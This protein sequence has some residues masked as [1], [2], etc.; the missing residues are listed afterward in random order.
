M[1]R[2]VKNPE[3]ALVCVLF[4]I[5]GTLLS[6]N[7]AGRRAFSKALSTTFGW[8]DPMRHVNF[9]GAT[10]LMVFDQIMAEK[11]YSPSRMER[12]SF[13]RNMGDELEATLGG[14]DPFL[15]DGVSEVIAKLSQD[16]RYLLG[17]VTG[18]VERCARIKLR[19]FDLD[20]AFSFGGFG[21]DHPDRNEIAGFA[22]TR[23]RHCAG[24]PHGIDRFYLV[25]DTPADMRAARAINAIAIGATT[26]DADAATLRESGA[27]FVIDEMTA[28]LGILHQAG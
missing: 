3:Y 22:V 24:E 23:A 9:S 28:L 20:S 11:D 17:L 19:C 6:A 8:E 14:G 16:N 2:D 18:N 27:D 21:H 7:G 12:N 4:D 5:D 15:Y 10:D 1:M 26:G 25:G 13:F